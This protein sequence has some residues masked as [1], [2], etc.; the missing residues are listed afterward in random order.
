VKHA[1]FTRRW[2]LGAAAA[3]LLPRKAAAHGVLGPVEPARP[4]PALGL[5]LHDGRQASLP[6]LLQGRLTALQ[7]MF[8]GCSATCPIQGAVFASLQR[9]V[10]GRVPGA[11]LLSV[12]IDPL[13]DDARALAAW[14]ARFE[15]RPEWIAAAPPVRHAEL[16][17]DFV[18]GRPAN[19]SA[20]DRHSAQTYLFD[21]KARL[22]YRC[23]E[24]ASAADIAAA[25]QALARQA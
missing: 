22:A 24:F 13:S 11:Q 23:A 7:L 10:L 2:L 25:M 20:S 16:M 15:A 12:S 14:R 5:T 8:T 21:A 19:A 1:R 4:A 17:L 9:Q 6:A 18:A 3:T